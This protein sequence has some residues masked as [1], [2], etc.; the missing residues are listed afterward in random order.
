MFVFTIS[1]PSTED[2]AVP[3]NSDNCLSCYCVWFNDLHKENGKLY[4]VQ[5]AICVSTTNQ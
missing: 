1:N 4:K 5:K 3:Y 2:F